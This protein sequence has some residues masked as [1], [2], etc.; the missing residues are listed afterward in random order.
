M[1]LAKLIL[2]L[3][4]LASVFVVVKHH[5][6]KEARKQAIREFVRFVNDP[7]SWESAPHVEL[8]TLPVPEPAPSRKV[9]T[10][11]AFT[12]ERDTK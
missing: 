7:K 1:K 12:S 2:A 8:P 9:P 11:G 3:V 4:I 5:R 10:K 6:E